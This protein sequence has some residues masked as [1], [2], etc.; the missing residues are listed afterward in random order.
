M[1]PY[2]F[3]G[4]WDK[5]EATAETFQDG[6]VTAGDLAVR[7][8]EGFVFLVDRKNDMIVSGGINLFPREIEEVL[9]QHDDVAEAARWWACRTSAGV[10]RSRAMSSRA[11]A[12]PSTPTRSWRF[13]R[14]HLAG[15]KVPKSVEVI[16][17]LPKN[18][19]GKV[20]RRTLRDLARR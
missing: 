5:P 18:A 8:E 11:K 7:D 6:W 3:N 13:A 2:L 20:L 1:S 17:A 12:R 15:Y 16:D 9:F 14:D 19:A 4:Y 10:R